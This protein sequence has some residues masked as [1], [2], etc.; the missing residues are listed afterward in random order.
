MSINVYW[1][2]LE[3]EWLRSEKPENI[4]N[5]FSK[6]NNGYKKTNVLQ[7]PSFKKELKN[8]YGI[9]S[10]YKY[11]FKFNN[12]E[13]CTKK[14][15]EIF[16]NRHVEVRSLEERTF[17]FR[18]WFVFFTEEDSLEMSQMAPFLEENNISKRC[19]VFPGKFDIGKWYRNIDF[20]FYL[21]K[22]Y[23]EFCI[24]EEEIFCYLKF[25]TEEKINFI[26]YRHDQEM[27]FFLNESISLKKYSNIKN[28]LEDLYKKLK[29]KKML[30]KK[31]KE[32]A[33]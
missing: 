1:A 33:I 6:T 10:L 14:Y 12:N 3:E 4:L 2:C 26:Q 31:I 19:I 32:K 28:S 20:A 8:V 27:Q 21:K 18:Q 7:C 22:E 25:Y 13:I 9:K 23:D 5:L 15:D 16:F 24:E 17:S 11:N 29:Y 30:I